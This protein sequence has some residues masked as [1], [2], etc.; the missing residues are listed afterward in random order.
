MVVYLSSVSSSSRYFGAPFRQ[1]INLPLALFAFV[2]SLVS[3]NDVRL[4]YICTMIIISPNV[5]WW[6]GLSSAFP[7]RLVFCKPHMELGPV[8][9]FMY[10]A[11]CSVLPHNYSHDNCVFRQM[12]HIFVSIFCIVFYGY[13]FCNICL[14]R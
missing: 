4:I 7:V 8:C 1:H 2:A 13:D 6:T 12:T 10:I 3:N 9:K 14:C 5:L 11:L